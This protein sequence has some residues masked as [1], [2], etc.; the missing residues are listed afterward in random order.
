MKKIFF[1]LI[2]L[3]FLIVSCGETTGVE[4]KN[5]GLAGFAVEFAEDFDLG[6]PEHRIENPEGGI[7]TTINITALGYNK[8]PYTKF[9]GE[10]EIG[11]LY[12]E[13]A[14]VSRITMENGYAGNVEV[15]MRYCL[16]NDRV[17]VKEV[18]QHD[19]DSKYEP[20]GK[21]G[22]S[23]VFYTEVATISAIQGTVKKAKG[24]PSA[25]NN[26]NLTLKDREMVVIAVI[27]GGFYLHEVGAED[28]SSVYMYTY[29]TPYVD[30]NVEENMFLPVGT[31]IESANGSV[32]EFFGFTEMSFPTFHP[33][34]VTKNGKKELKI[35]KSLVPEPKN[36]NDILTD[37]DEMEK[38]EASLVKV[39]N[40]T[41]AWF[42]EEDSS[43]IEYSQFPLETSDG[44][45]IMAQ[46]LYT[47]PLFNAVAEKPVEGKK[48]HHYNFTGILKQ[49]T[50]ARPSMWIL[51]PRDMNDIECLDCE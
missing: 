2:F 42:N 51:V 19:G 26:R 3:I 16:D 15:K 17:V 23:P 33:V 31:L 8:K 36:V 49:H 28:Y 40:V 47:A 35:D 21:M 12:G 25:F 22:V 7:V 27:E 41:V 13:N 44:K 37:N 10:V 43:Y 32:F 18:K 4:P 48:S 20:T 30:D 5:R 45:P 1:P 9:N 38:H 34:Y 24:N 46:T 39:E 50:S 6:S 14:A 11:L 29:S